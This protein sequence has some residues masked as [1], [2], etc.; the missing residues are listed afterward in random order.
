MRPLNVE[1]NRLKCLFDP[2][3]RNFQEPPKFISIYCH[4]R[5]LSCAMS[6]PLVHPC[7]SCGACCAFFRVSFHWTETNR[8]SFGVPLA[9]TSQISTYVN[10]MNGTDQLKPSCVGLV[11]VVGTSTTCSIYE[12]RPGACRDF[13]ASF[14]DGT[15][16]RHCEDARASKGLRLLDA[17]D[18]PR[19]SA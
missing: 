7:L 2:H 17:T 6:I 14:E 8:E 19:E 12:H 13:K 10:A 1:L 9:M 16:N 18:W 3:E 15:A 5:G 11:G 4:I